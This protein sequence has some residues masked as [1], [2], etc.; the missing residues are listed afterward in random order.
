MKS[1][2]IEYAG[3]GLSNPTYLE[4]ERRFVEAVDQEMVT[5]RSP[6]IVT[7]SVCSLAQC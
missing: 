1:P 7:L 3:S 4:G 6:R 5:T 2:Y